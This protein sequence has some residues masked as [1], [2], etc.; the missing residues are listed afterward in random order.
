M[1]FDQ[2]AYNREYYKRNAESL[3]QRTRARYA[4]QQNDPEY[5]LK[6]KLQRELQHYGVPMSVVFRKTGGRCHYC[7]S[8]AQVVHHLDGDGRTNERQGLT[9]G[10]AIDRLV[11]ACRSCHLELHR[12]AI[13]LTKKTRAN[14]YWARNHDHCLR[15]GTNQRRHSGHGLCVNCAAR[16]R[17]QPHRARRLLRRVRKL[18][19]GAG[20]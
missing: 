2:Q 14:G 1:P 11:P 9:P 15:C 6:R 10:A 16:K 17:R 18:R 20:V 5:K 13:M 19:K 3:R 8:P 7:D 4:S 12:A